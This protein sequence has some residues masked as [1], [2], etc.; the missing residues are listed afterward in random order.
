MTE[1][2]FDGML[3][4]ALLEAQDRRL[5]FAFEDGPE[6]VWSPE[7]EAVM[8]RILADPF[9]YGKRRSLPAWRRTL[10]RVGQAAACLLLAGSLA[11]ATLPPAR[12][13]VN[14]VIRMAMEWTDTNTRFRFQGEAQGELGLWRPT[15]LPEGY[16]EVEAFPLGMGWDIT[17]EN[18][19]EEQIIFTYVLMEEGGMYNFDNEHSDYSEMEMNG[20]PAHLF[21]T[22][23]EGWPSHLVWFDETGQTSYYL[24]TSVPV[25][26]V[27]RI[28]QSVAAQ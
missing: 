13:W 12:A 19:A 17:Y 20:Q 4:S 3:R 1:Q 25:E 9:G 6:L 26:E 8:E 5:S 22:N 10:V 2:E 15:Y 28:A 21:A 7:R 11:Y 14:Q 27:L 23:T 24:M 16:E 18:D